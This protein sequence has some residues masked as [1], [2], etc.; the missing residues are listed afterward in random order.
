MNIKRIMAREGLIFIVVATLFFIFNMLY[1]HYVVE[2]DKI[3]ATLEWEY[4]ITVNYINGIA[5]GGKYDSS[6]WQKYPDVVATVIDKDGNRMCMN[7]HYA[8]SRGASSAQLFDWEENKP[9][10]PNDW[11]DEDELS[12]QEKKK[13]E[14][15]RN[16]RKEKEKPIRLLLKSYEDSKRVVAISSA[17]FAFLSL[18]YILY[19]VA[20]LIKLLIWLI[21]TKRLTS[22]SATKAVKIAFSK[23]VL[24]RVALVL[25]I[26]F[27]SVSLLKSCGFIE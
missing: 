4:K 13:Y 24:I 10:D 5:W 7:R 1:E 22:Q 26:L 12:E 18:G 19:I 25:G 8:L 17:L 9:L 11:K 15:M 14:E 21:K 6:V 2:D 23:D 16:E 3:S 20:R 27:L